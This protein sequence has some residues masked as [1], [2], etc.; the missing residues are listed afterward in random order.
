[1]GLHHYSDV[2]EGVG[3]CVKDTLLQVR[4]ITNFSGHSKGLPTSKKVLFGLSKVA[5]TKKNS[6]HT[7]H[8]KLEEH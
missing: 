1:M 7:F 2:L 5:K 4:R 3:R 6:S 8:I